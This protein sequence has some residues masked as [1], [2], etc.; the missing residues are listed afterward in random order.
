M[1]M[2]DIS[3]VTAFCSVSQTIH[4]AKGWLVQ[5]NEPEKSHMQQVATQSSVEG[6]QEIAGES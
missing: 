1:Q 2:A 5:R 6:L 4:I 3:T